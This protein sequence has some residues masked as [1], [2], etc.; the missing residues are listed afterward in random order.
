MIECK[1]KGETVSTGSIKGI[2]WTFL[3]RSLLSILY[4]PKNHQTYRVSIKHTGQER[5]HENCDFYSVNINIY[6]QYAFVMTM[7]NF[8]WFAGTII[9]RSPITWVLNDD[10]NGNGTASKTMSSIRSMLFD[11]GFDVVEQSSESCSSTFQ[12]PAPLP[13]IMKPIDLPGHLTS[14]G[15]PSDKWMLSSAEAV[16]AMMQNRIKTFMAGESSWYWSSFDLSS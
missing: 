9:I 3:E 6:F 1:Q 2:G 15:S 12:L 10:S 7:A 16:A 5:F 13:V 4:D 14:N 11:S 8:D